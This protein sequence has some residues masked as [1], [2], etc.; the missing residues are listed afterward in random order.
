M[1]PLKQ[2]QFECSTPE[3]KP[4]VAEDKTEVE[5]VIHHYGN[6]KQRK[7]ELCFLREMTVV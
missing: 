6:E 7:K 5:N 1:N 3:R 2:R 4:L